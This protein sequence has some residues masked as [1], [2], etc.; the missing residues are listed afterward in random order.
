MLRVKSRDEGVEKKIRSARKRSGERRENVSIC[1]TR[2]S[3]FSKSIFR[4]LSS[5]VI[6]PRIYLTLVWLSHG[7]TSNHSDCR[8]RGKLRLS[9]QSISG[10]NAKRITNFLQIFN[11]W[12]KMLI[13]SHTLWIVIIFLLHHIFWT[14]MGSIFVYKLYMKKLKVSHVIENRREKF[15]R[16]VKFL[17]KEIAEKERDVSFKRNF[18]IN[19]FCFTHFFFIYLMTHRDPLPGKFHFILSSYF[20]SLLYKM[21]RK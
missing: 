16:K 19:I 2:S 8:I 6:H 1:G 11:T 3:I 5:G 4:A 18:F 12:S 17:S 13:Q 14:N 15:R 20:A 9:R 7:K 21:R 10:N